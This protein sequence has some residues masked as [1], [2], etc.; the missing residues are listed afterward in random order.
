MDHSQPKT[1][2][3]L[4]ELLVVITIIGILISLLLPAV[5]AAREAA[6]R[7]QCSNNLKQLALAMHGFHEQRGTLPPGMNDWFGGTWMVYILPFTEQYNLFNQYVNLGGKMWNPS[8]HPGYRDTP[9]S[10]ITSSRLATAT[11]PSDTANKYTASGWN[12]TKHNYAV[13]YGNTGQDNANIGENYTPRADL[14]GVIFLGAPFANRTTFTFAQIKDGL[15]NTL[16]MAEL[17]QTEAADDGRGLTWW[18]DG[19][20]FSA[21]L[22]P[23]SSEPDITTACGADVVE[24]PCASVSSTMPSMFGSRSRHPGGV[25]VALGD[26]SVRFVN[27]SINID[28][29]R[30]LATTRGNEPISGDF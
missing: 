17:I 15:S 20:G 29:W 21:Y 18:G 9:N 30:A 3:T 14:N 25:H 22:A 7:T 13:N 6:R 26:G 11:C 23:N 24:P 5:Q 8:T 4:V 1:G 12:L 10:I 16:L 28:T 2:F 19:A 27:N